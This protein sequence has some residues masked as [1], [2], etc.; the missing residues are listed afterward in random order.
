MKD[1]HSFAEEK[2]NAENLP[3]EAKFLHHILAEDKEIGLE[4][5]SFLFTSEIM[6]KIRERQ[7]PTFNKFVIGFFGL[8]WV[9]ILAFAI[10]YTQK[11]NESFYDWQLPKWETPAWQFTFLDNPFWLML[12][13]T[14]LLAI[15][16]LV[17]QS[18]LQHKKFRKN[19]K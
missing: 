17:L 1:L 10:I 13:N 9:F 3:Q 8:L 15:F 7:Q 2:Q 11:Q 14:M 19:F 16:L 5:T 12:A 4:Q 6:Q 18:I